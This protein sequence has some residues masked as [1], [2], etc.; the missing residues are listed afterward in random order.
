MRLLRLL[1]AV[2]LMMAVLMVTGCQPGVDST[3]DP[4]SSTDAPDTVDST[5]TATVEPSPEPTATPPQILGRFATDPAQIGYLRVVHVAPEAGPVDI[6]VDMSPMVSGI[7]Y[8]LA[9]GRTNVLH[10][11]YT[12]HV[13]QRGTQPSADEPSPENMLV[14]VPVDLS[15]GR[16]LLLVLTET[17]GELRLNVFEESSE[18]L[19]SGMSRVSVVH[20]VQ[21]APDVTVRSGSE[22]TPTDQPSDDQSD[23][24]AADQPAVQNLIG[25][26]AFG[27]RSATVEIPSGETVLD[28]VLD[29]ATTFSYPFNPLPGIDY[30]LV[31]YG[32]SPVVEQL[33][34]LSYDHPV[35]GRAQVRV[36]N[37]STA[38]TSL[39]VYLNGQLFAPNVGVNS[40]G[41]RQTIPDGSYTVEVYPAGTD[42]NAA[43][44]ADSRLSESQLTLLPD[45]T[46]ALIAFGGAE[47]LRLTPFTE[48]LSPLAPETARIAY[49]NA[50]EATPAAQIG[51]DSAIREELGTIGFG[52]GT[53]YLPINVGMSTVFWLS[54]EDGILED[55]EFEAESGQSYLYFLTGNLTPFILSESVGIDEALVDVP[56]DGS[57]AQ[58]TPSP[59]TRI[60]VVNV[61]DDGL[62]V[63]FTAEGLNVAEGLGF[64][65]SSGF[66][67]VQTGTFPIT[68]RQSGGELMLLERDLRLS[69]GGDIT[70]VLYGPSDSLR[71]MTISEAA[72]MGSDSESTLRFINASVDETVPLGLIVA[73][74]SAPPQGDS[75][76]SS[77]P[78]SSTYL[79]DSQ[80]PLSVS[81]VIPIPLPSADF[82][83]S[84]N[85]SNLIGTRIYNMTLEEGIHYDIV[86]T[87]LPET[88]A[89]RAVM[90]AYPED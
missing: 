2:G 70:V 81:Q 8:G 23:D 63:D 89:I 19:S 25:P 1:C 12:V 64:G 15:I 3:P 5:P 67:E 10:G 13:V 71:V 18:P 68:V 34:V 54:E 74:A 79:I 4:Q 24:Q 86:A 55:I 88:D 66:T 77:V 59:N 90:V 72:G 40:A 45:T 35:P 47:T 49:I 17:S 16:S 31:F 43:D 22:S 60:R 9:S 41:E 6:Y 7:E 76:Q 28:F 44:A 32:R 73:E 36:I 82:I 42:P 80:E 21:S 46:Q 39:D 29:D 87:Y 30:I 65:E 56:Q 20:A 69:S 52:Q 37:A 61:N 27:E 58:F 51:N 85:R 14:S 48:D 50:R 78:I 33:G 84:D 38:P 11:S 57:E 83:I 26:V 62:T 75:G 53:A